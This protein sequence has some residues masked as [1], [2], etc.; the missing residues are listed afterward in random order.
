MYLT[1]YVQ[2]QHNRTQPL[3]QQ[4]SEADDCG[5]SCVER[6]SWQPYTDRSSLIIHSTSLRIFFCLSHFTVRT[7]HLNFLSVCA[8]LCTDQLIAESWTSYTIKHPPKVIQVPSVE[9]LGPNKPSFLPM[10]VPADLIER[11][12]AFHGY[13][14]VWFVGQF[15]QY[16][17]RPSQQLSDYLEERR[18]HLNI[19]H[20][21]VGL[22][23]HPQTHTPCGFECMQM[24]DVRI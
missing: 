22:V 17:M 10:A 6:T 21:I 5:I 1:L 14:F 11:L 7:T 16:L 3:L 4:S 13:P 19:T 2:V 23:L 8:P 18:K 9:S 24:Y 12:S 20:P 15:L